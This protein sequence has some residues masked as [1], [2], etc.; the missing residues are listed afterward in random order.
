VPVGLAIAVTLPLARPA[1][2]AEVHQAASFKVVNVTWPADVWT[3]VT[4]RAGESR[5]RPLSL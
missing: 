3:R 4:Q 1:V 2:A 5:V